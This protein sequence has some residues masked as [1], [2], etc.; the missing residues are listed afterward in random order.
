M[1]LKIYRANEGEGEKN[2]N[3]LF[4]LYN[5]MYERVVRE[6]PFKIKI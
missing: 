3:E 4:D 1:E 6:C 2:I 5:C